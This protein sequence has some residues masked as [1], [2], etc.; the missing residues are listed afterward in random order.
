MTLYR[1]DARP[2]FPSAT[3][4]NDSPT[5]GFGGYGDPNNDFQITTGAF[6]KDFE[7]AYPVPHKIRRNYTERSFSTDPF[8]DGTA[9]APLPFWN[10]FTKESRDTLVNGF[11]GDF[12]GFHALFEGPVVSR[13]S[14][15]VTTISVMVVIRVGHC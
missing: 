7:L 15:A 14:E 12:E 9:P 11:V 2:D 1:A 4:F 5:S 10:Y 13:S 3:I 8:G 6:A